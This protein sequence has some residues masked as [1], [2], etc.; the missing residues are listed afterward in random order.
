MC[1]HYGSAIRQLGVPFEDTCIL[2]CLQTSALS[3]CGVLLAEQ[4]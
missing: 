3:L 2:H 1:S 4:A